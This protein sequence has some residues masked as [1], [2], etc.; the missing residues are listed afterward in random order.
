[1]QKPVV[2]ESLAKIISTA[3]LN[4]SGTIASLLKVSGYIVGKY[5]LR[6]QGMEE[7]KVKE[8]SKLDFQKASRDINS[9]P[10]LETIKSLL[11]GDLMTNKEYEYVKGSLQNIFK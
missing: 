2:S 8:F 7:S 11:K 10:V 6:I 5:S 9:S 3:F 4:E 1:M